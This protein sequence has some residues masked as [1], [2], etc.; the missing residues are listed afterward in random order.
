MSVLSVFLANSSL[1]VNPKA[2]VMPDVIG[3]PVDD[4]SY[5][6]KTA[7]LRVSTAQRSTILELLTE[8]LLNNRH[9]LD[10]KSAQIPQSVYTLASKPERDDLAS[11]W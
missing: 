9:L 8:L 2:F 4:V 11:L 6:F 1:Y 10:I 3:Q 7:G 5:F